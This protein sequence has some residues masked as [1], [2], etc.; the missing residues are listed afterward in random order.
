MRNIIRVLM[1]Q[2][3]CSEFVKRAEWK[4]RGRISRAEY[5]FGKRRLAKLIHNPAGGE[6]RLGGSFLKL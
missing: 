2:R 1:N 3:F 6:C 5:Y 4:G